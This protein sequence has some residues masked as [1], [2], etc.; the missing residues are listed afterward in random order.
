[1]KVSVLSGFLLFTTRSLCFTPHKKAPTFGQGEIMKRSVSPIFWVELGLSA[2]SALS[3]ALTLIWPQ[4]IEMLFG[5]DPDGGDGSDE[6]GFTLG[7]AIATVT[8][9]AL[10]R[11]EWRRAPP[12]TAFQR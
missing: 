7:L 10:A 11:R 3:L 5:V 8:L 12:R 1:M 4:W 2:L 9:L 6:M